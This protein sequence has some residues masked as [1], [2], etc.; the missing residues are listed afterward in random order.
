[1]TITALD[2]QIGGD[3][4]PVAPSNSFTAGFNRIY[5]FVKFSAMQGGVLWRRQLV[6]DGK[7]LEDSNYLWGLAQEG[8]T[9]F[10]FGREDGFKPGSY[11]VRLYLGQNSKPI[12]TAAFTV[13]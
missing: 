13:K 7:I 10:F 1:L 3:F 6:D 4:G 12:T 9:Y 2:T 11:E 8:T 5:Y